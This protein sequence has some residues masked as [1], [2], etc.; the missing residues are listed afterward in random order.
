MTD[1]TTRYRVVIEE[2]TSGER[3]EHSWEQVY[4]VAPQGELSYRDVERVKRFEDTRMIFKAESMH[5]PS[6]R[7]LAAL[8]EPAAASPGER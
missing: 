6:I 8:M 1:T 2:I 5:R 4:E 7:D 3:S